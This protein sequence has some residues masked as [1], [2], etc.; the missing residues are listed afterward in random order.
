MET[1]VSSLSTNILHGAESGNK[2]NDSVVNLAKAVAAHLKSQPA[3]ALQALEGAP[4]DQ[5]D[6]PEILAARAHLRMDLKQYE[7]AFADYDHL[8]ALR[9]SS[10]DVWFQSGVCLHRLGRLE[11]ALPRFAKSADLD[12]SRSDAPLA[13]GV[14]LLHLKRAEEALE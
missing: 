3:D 5:K 7:L 10:A 11:A 14:C 12:P 2:S 9:P 8:V 13:M 4:A 6:L 1:K